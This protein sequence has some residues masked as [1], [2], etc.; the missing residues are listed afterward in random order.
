M[1]ATPPFA[2]SCD[3]DGTITLADMVQGLLAR[4]ATPEWLDIEARW[5]AGEIDARTCLERQTQL[6]R[7]SPAELA[8]WVDAQP[9]DPDVPAF[10]R[11]CAARGLDVRILSDGYD[12]VIDRVLRRIGV[13]GVPVFANRLQ[14][15]SEDRWRVSFPFMRP[16]CPAGVCK[17][18]AASSTQPRLHIGDGRSDFCLADHSDRV[19][20][21]R[22]LLAERRAR[23]VPAEAFATFAELRTLVFGPAHPQAGQG[24]SPRSA[25]A[26]PILVGLDS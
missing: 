10:L 7:A 18:A 19:L 2:V 11:D 6:L 12:W 13:E 24:A 5:E 8:D 15:A 26:D 22:S 25:P 23:G 9:V 16:G 3:F 20:A 14:Y 4:F 21:T 1:R 17:C